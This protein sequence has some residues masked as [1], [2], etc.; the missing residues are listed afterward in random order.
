MNQPIVRVPTSG[1]YIVTKPKAPGITH[2]GILDVGNRLARTGGGVAPV[3]LQQAPP[4]LQ[5]VDFF[6]TGPWSIGTRLHD[7]AMVRERVALAAKDPKYD[8]FRN[9]C[10]DLIAFVTS[11]VRHSQQVT[12]FVVVAGL[13]LFAV[14]VWPRGARGRRRSRRIPTRRF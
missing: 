10:E 14:A 4:Q 9:N 13:V 11:G 8:L 12:N 3:V 5:Y 2:F 7:E 6:T 1:L